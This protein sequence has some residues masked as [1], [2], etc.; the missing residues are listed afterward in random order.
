LDFVLE[1]RRRL[2]NKNK[3]GRRELVGCG[4]IVGCGRLEKSS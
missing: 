4:I 3:K 2:K 1:E